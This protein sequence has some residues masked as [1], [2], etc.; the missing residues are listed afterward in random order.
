MAPLQPAKMALFQS[1]VNSLRVLLSD[2][3]IRTG[4]EKG[5]DSPFEI[6][7]VVFGPFD[8]KPDP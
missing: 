1:A 8:F 6:V 7:D 4:F 2:N 5:V 3:V